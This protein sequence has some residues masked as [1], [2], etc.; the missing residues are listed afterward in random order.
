MRYTFKDQAY[1]RIGMR[2]CSDREVREA[3]VLV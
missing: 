1:S 2:L 3:E